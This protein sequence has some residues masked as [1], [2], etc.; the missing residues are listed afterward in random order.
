MAINSK[1]PQYALFFDDWIVMRDTYRGERVVKEKGELYL[2]ATAGMHQ[3]GMGSE[4]LGRKRYDA[5]RKRA[6]FHD[7][8]SD[9]V[10]AMM[11]LLHSKPPAIELPPAL[12]DLRENATPH[13]ES[14]EA[15]LRRI[16]E[17]QLVTGRVG[18]LLDMPENPDPT[19]PLPHIAVYTA[20]NIINWDDGEIDYEL[21]SLNL[22]VLDES[23]YVRLQDFEWEYKNKY[24]VLVKGAVDENEPRGKGVYRQGLFE[25]TDLNFTEAGLIEPN[26]RGNTLDIVPFVFIN[27]KDILPK[28]DDPPLLGLASLTLAIY[29]GEAD[30]RQ[31]LFMQ[32]QDTLVVI[33]GN[34]DDETRTGAGA[35]IAVPIGGD[36]K[37]IGVSSQ[38]LPEQRQGLENDKAAARNKAGQLIDTRSRE[39]ES[40]DALLIRVA[41]QTATLNTIAKT[42]AAGLERL[43]RIAARW[44][45]ADPEQ[46]SVT[47]NLDFAQQPFTSRELVE[48]MTAKSLGAPLSTES[49]HEILVD[50]G[51]T[52]KD[53]EEEMRLIEEEVPVSG[54]GTGAGGNPEDD[55][56]PAG[57]NDSEG[58]GAGGGA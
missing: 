3:D 41:A 12:E 20:E 26:I 6:V 11:G 16:N 28:P 33:G 21:P 17:E 25:G 30:Y 23:E 4:E 22:V 48:L 44:V 35:K 46:V 36:A 7:F 34:D 42:G 43:L 14:L 50:K 40:G 49:I 52:Q 18:L 13:G 55:N 15:L 54:T 19:R 51:F 9:A 57:D 10:E 31:N 47:P 27:T 24:R 53:Y 58:A 29:R 39:K 37:Y 8:V 38:G 45:G 32:G 5:Y 1:H 56:P 2:P